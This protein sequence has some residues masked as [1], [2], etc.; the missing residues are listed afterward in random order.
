M[1]Y[2]ENTSIFGKPDLSFLLHMTWQRQSSCAND[3]SDEQDR[4]VSLN[5]IEAKTTDDFLNSIS[6]TT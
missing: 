2:N 6:A 4:W 3:P 1:L 5:V